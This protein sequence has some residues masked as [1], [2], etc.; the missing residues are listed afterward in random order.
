MSEM[1]FHSGK[2]KRF[3]R[4]DGESNAAY[5]ERFANDTGLTFSQPKEEILSE[6]FEELD[7]GGPWRRQTALVV[8]DEIW[9]LIDHKQQDEPPEVMEF[10]LLPDGSYSFAYYFYNGGTCLPEVLESSIDK[11]K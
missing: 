9:Q 5:A 11:I 6:I 10:S 4:I 3:P 1:E 2:A 7:L 8:N